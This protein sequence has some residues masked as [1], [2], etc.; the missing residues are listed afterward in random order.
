MPAFADGDEETVGTWHCLCSEILKVEHLNHGTSLPNP[1][2]M[3]NCSESVINHRH[4]A[5]WL[6]MP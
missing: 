4:D 5:A 2:N 6:M 3:H 1:A